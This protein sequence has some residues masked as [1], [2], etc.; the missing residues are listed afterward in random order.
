MGCYLSKPSRTTRAKTDPVSLAERGEI[1]TRAPAVVPNPAFAWGAQRYVTAPLTVVKAEA[2]ASHIA[3]EGSPSQ[4][5]SEADASSKVAEATASHEAEASSK[6]SE[7]AIE[8]AGDDNKVKEVG[9]DQDLEGQKTYPV[10]ILAKGTGRK[11]TS[12][13]FNAQTYFKIIESLA[14]FIE[15]NAGTETVGDLGVAPLSAICSDTTECQHILDD[16]IFPAVSEERY[17]KL[18]ASRDAEQEIRDAKDAGL[19]EHAHYRGCD[20]TVANTTWNKAVTRSVNN[21][22]NSSNC[23]ED[24]AS[25]MSSID[26]ESVGPTVPIDHFSVAN[27]SCISSADLLGSVNKR[28]ITRSS[29]THGQVNVMASVEEVEEVSEDE[30]EDEEEG[31]DGM[32]DTDFIYSM[33]LATPD[34]LED[35][36]AELL[37][38]NES[39][40][41][42]FCA[43]EAKYADLEQVLEQTKVRNQGLVRQVFSTQERA[44]RAERKVAELE[45]ATKQH[46]SGNSVGLGARPLSQLHPAQYNF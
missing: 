9:I 31:G 43:L 7:A 5:I 26:L 1:K 45:A 40:V 29:S 4:A 12:V 24:D 23:D 6:V 3:T 37:K 10:G 15:V 11:N 44:N 36:V 35:R 21:E 30:N 17:K 28:T 8:A 18:E 27:E 25:S 38:D 13:A 39:I 19:L 41:A 22:E 46:K 34:D 16:H 33:Y 32:D 14:E 2:K 42:K 20:Q